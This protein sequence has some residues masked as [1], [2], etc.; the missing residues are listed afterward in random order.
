[1]VNPGNIH[2][3][4]EVF[5]IC[6]SAVIGCMVGLE[7]EIRRKPAGFRT[8]A[9]ISVGATIFTICSYKLGFPDNEDRIA[10]NII[11]G[12]GFLGAGVIYRNGF[13]VSGITTAATIWIAA[14][15]GMLIGIGEYGLT[16]LSLVTSI[17]ILSVMEYLQ[18]YIDS[19]FQHR[20]YIITCRGEFG[21]DQLKEEFAQY[22]LK[23]RNFK[24]TR[25]DTQTSFEFD[26]SGRET[27]LEQ[28]N[29]WLKQNKEVF[30]FVW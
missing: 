21:H 14:A 17:I 8:L 2:Y 11:T 1:M 27:N 3:N 18:D 4:Q 20:N 25:Q 30:S 24:E 16:A 5:K 6:L 10:A 13:S 28:F 29:Q 7:R 22:Q 15:L 23:V 26:I 9:I 12:V 19:R